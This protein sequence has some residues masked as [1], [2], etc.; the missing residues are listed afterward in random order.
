MIVSMIARLAFEL[1]L[2]QGH[3]HYITGS[4]LRIKVLLINMYNDI[5][6]MRWEKFD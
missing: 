1:G 2:L 6:Y 4:L 5:Y 3:S